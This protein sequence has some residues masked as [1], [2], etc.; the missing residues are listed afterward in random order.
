MSRGYNV[1]GHEFTRVEMGYCPN[2]NTKVK[3]G[4]E[5]FLVIFAVIIFLLAFAWSLGGGS[6]VIE[7]D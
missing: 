4:I 7:E 3:G 5:V 1:L 2:T 6:L